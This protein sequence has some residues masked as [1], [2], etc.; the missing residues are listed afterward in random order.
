MTQF[1][2][3]KMKTQMPALPTNSKAK[4]ETQTSNVSHCSLQVNI[5]FH[6]NLTR[7]FILVN[8]S[9]EV[10]FFY[11]ED[12]LLLFGEMQEYLSYPLKY[13][14][15]KHTMESYCGCAICAFLC[16]PIV[17]F[18]STVEFTWYSAQFE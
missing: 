15:P 18:A 4:K 7:S 13:E 9:L 11:L 17:I 10:C 12:W 5:P 6:L 8:T 2:T 3:D 14:S 16:V 1:P